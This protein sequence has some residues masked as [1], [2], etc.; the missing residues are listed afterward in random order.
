ML[1]AWEANLQAF[2]KRW[3]SYDSATDAISK[4]TIALW[5]I[6]TGGSIIMLHSLSQI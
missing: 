5:S 2:R 6:D 1:R 4:A 3:I